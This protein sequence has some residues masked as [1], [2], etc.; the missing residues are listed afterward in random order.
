MAVTAFW[1]CR[2][3]GELLVHSEK[4][5][6]IQHDVT[7]STRISRLVVNNRTVISFHLPWTKTTGIAGGDCILTATGDDLCPVHAMDNH[8]LVNHSPSNPDT[9]LFAYHIHHSTSWTFLIKDYFLLF[10][11]GIFKRLNLE[12][13]FGHSYRIGGSLE[14]LLAGVEPEVVMKVGGW[15]SL[16]FLIYWRRL[17]QVIPAAITRA[18]DKRIKAFASR[19][20]IRDEISDF[21][22]EDDST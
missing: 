1:G 7:R 16:C 2:R 19:H 6:S 8:L 15:T 4:K 17:E 9:P 22:F 14:L 18:W 21:I 3:L 11:C 13:V 10:S 5:F 12:N 20:G